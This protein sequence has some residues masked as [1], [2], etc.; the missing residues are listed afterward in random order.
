LLTAN[1]KKQIWE[2]FVVV[3]RLS[4]R[5]DRW[6]RSIAILIARD[7]EPLTE[8]IALLELHQGRLSF[9]AAD[10]SHI[11][12]SDQIPRKIPA[13]IIEPPG[14]ED[15]WQ[16]ITPAFRAAVEGGAK[17]IFFRLPGRVSPG[18]QAFLRRLT[19]NRHGR[20]TRSLEIPGDVRVVILT[21]E[22]DF[23]NL[24]VDGEFWQISTDVIGK[25]LFPWLR[26]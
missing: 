14:R 15:S 5:L 6:E 3:H 25:Y 2:W 21:T 20:I 12:F 17:I 11:V 13:V 26:V 18:Y 22:S 10:F 7:E 9:G 8:I 19:Q 23:E 24:S 1:D 16:D 4:Q